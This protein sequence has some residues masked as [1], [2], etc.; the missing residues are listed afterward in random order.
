MFY[1]SQPHVSNVLLVPLV[2]RHL[3]EKLIVL[4]LQKLSDFF[5]KVSGMESFSLRDHLINFDNQTGKT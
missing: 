5:G 1:C 3:N 2:E 4:F